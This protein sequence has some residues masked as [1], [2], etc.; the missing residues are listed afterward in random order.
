MAGNGIICSRLRVH[1]WFS[2]DFQPFFRKMLAKIQGNVDN[3]ML[4]HCPNIPFPGKRDKSLH[5]KFFTRKKRIIFF[6]D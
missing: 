2:S 6:R 4:L 1:R 5:E 3:R